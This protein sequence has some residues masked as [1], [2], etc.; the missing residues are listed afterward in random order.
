MLGGGC[1]YREQK[2]GFSVC[3]SFEETPGR[4]GNKSCGNLGEREAAE[5]QPRMQS[6]ESL[7]WSVL[8]ACDNREEISRLETSQQQGTGGRR[9]SQGL[10][11]P[12]HT[13]SG[14]LRALAVT[15]MGLIKDTLL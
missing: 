1:L 14:G 6:P 8:G 11:G 5:K 9:R 15:L 7:W 2:G 4:Q 10:A 12:G 13:E 3:V